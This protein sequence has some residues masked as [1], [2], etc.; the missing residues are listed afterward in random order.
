MDILKDFYYKPRIDLEI[1]KKYRDGLIAMTACAGGIVGAHLANDDFDLAM[2]DAE[3][4][5]DI[6]GDDFYLE[7]QNHQL[8]KEK[9][10][11]EGLPIIAKKLDI[12][13][14]A[15]NDCHYIKREHAI[16]HN[17]Y[18]LIPESSVNTTLDYTKLKY[19][20]DQ[21]YFKSQDEMLEA[22]S[23]FPEALENT[24]EVMEKCNLKLDLYKNLMPHF[25]LPENSPANT[26]DDYFEEL[27]WKG[28]N[29]KFDVITDE[30][31]DRLSFEIK[32]IRQMG[33]SGYFL[34]VQ[35]FINKAKEMQ[36]S[37]GPGRGS[38][39][40]SLA[41]YTLGITNLNPLD[42]DLLFERFLNPDR[43]SM[44][45][46]DVDFAD[47]RRGEVINYVREKYG[48][49]SVGQIIT[50]GKLTSKAALKD[51]GRVLGVPLNTIEQITKQIPVL[52]GKVTPIKEAVDTI[53][54]LKWVKE[55]P[56][57]KVKELIDY[58]I[59][60]ENLN[61]NAST[62][63]AGVVIVP[64]NIDDYVPLY[65]TTSMNEA[66]TQYNMKDL[67]TA[68][69]LKMDFL[70]LK[71]LTIIENI[72]KMVRKNHGI[73]LDLD[74]IPL[75]DPKTFEL[76]GKG[77]TVGVFQFE[78]APMQE[79]LKKLKPT[80][81]DD[82]VAMNALYRP[83]PMDMIDDFIAR[84]LG[85]Q[86]IEYLH[87]MMAPILKTTYGI[88]VYQEQV[89]QI[90]SK[91][92]GFSLAGADLLRRAM[93]KKDVDLMTKQKNAFV[94]GAAK[95]GIDKKIATEIF[96][97]IEKFAKYGFNKSHSVAYSIV[98]YQTAYL[99]ANYPVE[100]MAANLLNEIGNTDKIVL[101][102]D[103]C[104]KMNIKVLPPDVN[105][106]ESGFVCKNNQIRFGLEAIKNVGTTAVQEIISGVNKIGTF[107]DIFHF[108]ESLD[109]RV[110]N[111]KT[112]ESLILAG[113]MDSFSSNRKQMYESVD[114]AI[115]HGQ[116]GADGKGYGAGKPV[117][118]R[119]KNR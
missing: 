23:D 95:N 80:C 66:V 20:T 71:T 42:Y 114:K 61:R 115:Q 77:Q 28:L 9:K 70:G 97:M 98:A 25:P 43:V 40:G 81:I 62:H 113:A 59:I 116:N 109:L 90:V 27:C 33:Y 53:P 82:L 12:K 37:V 112:I 99:K 64:G 19:G 60:L 119:S 96:D 63:A 49:N 106:H 2:E 36:I 110:V 111:R 55:S 78:S 6:F 75:T 38:A 41:S 26:L 31:K 52:Q 103:D 35:D 107:K 67:E 17:I 108:C 65:K 30:L 46:I 18:L 13:I 58:S 84:K 73:E 44:P 3:I 22:F 104:R 87:P 102:I 11:I 91:L 101:F 72:K 94:E 89:M 7:M 21:I 83:G 1:L 34:I 15:T 32:I 86:K 74:E 48:S 54:E 14:V 93:G 105:E 100:F 39:A 69:I 10:I 85:R 4:Y 8:E 5:K 88:I 45:D 92:G 76:F 16:A 24:M 56:D 79:Y 51:V 118:R 117:W 57:P 29:N 68:G 47:D 50:F